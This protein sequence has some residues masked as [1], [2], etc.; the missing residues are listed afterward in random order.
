MLV[1]IGFD[2][3]A[4]ADEGL[5]VVQT[6][7]TPL[8]GGALAAGQRSRHYPGRSEPGASVLVDA[9]LRVQDALKPPTPS[10][11]RG[12]AP[13]SSARD[14]AGRLSAAATPGSPGSGR[15]LL[16]HGRRRP[17]LGVGQP[18]YYLVVVL[19]RSELRPIGG[20]AGNYGIL[21]LDAGR[22]YHPS[23]V[24]DDVYKLD[25]QYFQT[26]CHK[27]RRLDRAGSPAAGVLLVVALSQ[28]GLPV[29]LGPAGRGL[30]SQL[31]HRCSDRDTDRERHPQHRPQQR[32]L[33]RGHCLHPGPHPAIDEVTGNITLKSGVWQ[34]GG[35]P[36]NLEYLIHRISSSA[37]HRRTDRKAFTH[38]LSAVMLAKI[39]TLHGSQLKAVFSVVEKC[40]KSKD[41]ELYFAAPQAEL[42]LQQLGLASDIRTGNGDGFYVVDTNDGG[43]KANTYVSEQQ[44][45][46]V[47]LLPN[48]GALHHLE[49]AVTYNR[50]GLSFLTNY[51]GL[52]GY[53][54]DLPARRCLHPGLL[55]L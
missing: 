23:L 29:W 28:S 14:Q 7:L 38:E 55:R 43:N 45:D 11:I 12:P 5:Q 3:S 44:T 8:Q 34:R 35:D 19:D 42:I 51:S 31:P 54:A 53:A 48:G 13:R 33:A 50:K 52:H 26:N 16:P 47:T 49:I 18:A 46:V 1:R 32:A 22:E 39:K 6:I 24:S 10:S 17:L 15:A 2:L 9:T 4:S 36:H 37:Q 21:E 40:L 20:F 41:L 25:H 27:S 30:V